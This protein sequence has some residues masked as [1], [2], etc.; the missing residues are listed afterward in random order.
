MFDERTYF[1]YLCILIWAKLLGLQ[2]GERSRN[3]GSWAAAWSSQQFWQRK[4][5]RCLFHSWIQAKFGKVQWQGEGFSDR[6]KHGVSELMFHDG[7][8]GSSGEALGFLAFCTVV[9]EGKTAHHQ[10]F[11]TGAKSLEFRLKVLCFP[12]STLP[13]HLALEVTGTEAKEGKESEGCPSCGAQSPSEPPGS[14]STPCS[15]VG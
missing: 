13:W 2:S 15:W 10:V 1:S 8:W 14:H 7:F 6:R 4:M 11:R 9:S 5:L 3:A 12:V